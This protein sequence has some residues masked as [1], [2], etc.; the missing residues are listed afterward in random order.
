M[1]FCALKR[2]GVICMWREE[3][4]TLRISNTSRFPGRFYGS[5]ESGDDSLGT[6][7]TNVRMYGS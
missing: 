2:I 3:D 4:E 1:I 7:S 5:A 6:G